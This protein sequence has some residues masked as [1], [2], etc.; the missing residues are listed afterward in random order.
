MAARS[1]V[2][3]G[4]GLYAIHGDA[5]TWTELGLGQ[6]PDDRPLYVGKAEASLIARDLNT[7]FGSGQTGSSTVRR[8]VAALLRDALALRGIPRNTKKPERPANFGLTG[9]HDQR[10]GEWM[11]SRLSLATWSKPSGCDSLLAVE[12]VLLARWKSPLNLRDNDSPWKADVLAAR[13]RMTVD[14]RRWARAHGFE[15]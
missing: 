4:P 7:H 8:S 1:H 13:T 11:A 3:T 12:R 15:I 10:L 9:P 2:P 6:P 14:A 5:R